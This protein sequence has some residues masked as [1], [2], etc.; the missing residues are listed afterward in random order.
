MT[1]CLQFSGGKDSLAC[2][3]LLRDQWDTLNVAWLNTGAAYPEMEAYMQMWKERLPG[4]VEVRSN[5]PEQ[6]KEYGW[7]ADVVPINSSA[8]WQSVSNQRGPLI[9]PYLACCMSNIWLPLHK[10]MID[11]GVTTIIKGQRIEDGRKSPVRNG[12]VIDGITF[13][14][15]IENWTTEQVFDYLDE[16][17][18]D[19]PP[20]Y[21]LGEQTG[22]DCWD[23]TAYLDENKRR[24]ENLPEERKAEVKR[25][26]GLIGQAIREQW[27]AH[28]E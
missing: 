15:P 21:G 18:A 1:V 9:Q 5:Q 12:D 14:M 24:I 2:L 13:L 17:G 3:Y 8:M 27:S 4:F 26:L 28:Y 23:C 10:A 25:R 11:M 7:P 22:R 19:L 20:G 16:V 6:V